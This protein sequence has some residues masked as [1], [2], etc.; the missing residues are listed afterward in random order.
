VPTEETRPRPEHFLALIREQQRG[1]LKVYLGFA[2]G[3]GKTYEMLQGAHSLKRQGVDVVVG[4]AETHGRAETAALL[5]GLEQVP[6][7]R[8]EYRGV[9]LEEMD[10]DAVLARRPTVALVDELAHTNAPGSRNA[11]RY[12]DV[13]ELRRAGIHVIS[14]LNVQHLESLYDMIERFTGVKVKER[15][16]DYVLAQADEV[17]NVD[18]TSEDLQERLRSGKVYPAERAERALEN[19]FTEQN[20]SQLRELAMEELARALDRRRQQRGGNAQPS[21]SERIMVCVSSRS[22]ITHLL[23]RKAA[24][25]AHRFSAPWYAVYIKT[26]SE[27]LER[28]EAATQ[29][30]ISDALTLAQ[31]LGGT[32]M[33]YGGPSFHDAVADFV[34]EYAITH[35][36]VGRT[37][38]PWYRRW[39]GQSP[40]DRLLRAVPNVDVTVVGSQT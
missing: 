31:Q 33:P 5:E 34:R 18:L 24:R 1:R 22:P 21:G 37:G 19:F 3:V 16:P 6:R 9:A 27:G 39:F 25:L 20:L 28:V 10:L 7:R 2:P 30:R 35:I 23:L 36:L 15:V 13:E 38:R 26:P 12:Q 11:K 17:V 32:S 29:R 40:L 4:V 8:V 14:T